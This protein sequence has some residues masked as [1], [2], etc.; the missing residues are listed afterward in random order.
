MRAGF[1][2]VSLFPGGSK[3]LAVCCF[4]PSPKRFKLLRQVL[5]PIWSESRLE[6]VFFRIDRVCEKF[7]GLKTGGKR[8][9]DSP[10][11]FDHFDQPSFDS[12]KCAGVALVRAIITR[13]C[14][15]SLTSNEVS[16][17]LPLH[18]ALRTPEAP[19]VSRPGCLWPRRASAASLQRQRCNTRIARWRCARDR[20][21]QVRIAL[22]PRK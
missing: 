6:L 17:P 11:T 9:K 10:G 19:A 12:C 3:K 13:A 16:F 20:A 8:H 1:E 15:K 21:N 5:P 14:G 18:R 22:N 7:Q 4:E 2:G